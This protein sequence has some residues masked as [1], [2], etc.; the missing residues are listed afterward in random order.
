MTGHPI[1]DMPAPRS[2]ILRMDITNICNL[3]CIG[4]ALF[5]ARKALREPAASMKVETFERI[6][7]EVFPY[8]CEVAL[9]CEAEPTLHPKFSRIMQI[10]ADK[11]ERST[12]LPVRMT[13]NAT[14]LTKDRLDAIFDSGLFGLAV[15]IDGFAPE[16]FS[17]IRKKG[18]ISKVFEAMDEIVRRRTAEKREFP[19][20]QINYTLM[21]SN[22]YELMDLIKYSRRWEL[23]SFVVTHV[24]SPP[25]K[26]MSRE[27]LMDWPE[28]SN[29]ILSQA[30]AKCRKY[31]IPG[32]F[33]APFPTKPGLW[34]R[35]ASR[36]RPEPVPEPAPADSTDLACS[37][38][39][40]MLKIRWNG[41]V[42]PCDL[43]N[44]SNPLGSLETQSF[45]DIWMSEKYVELRSGLFNGNPTFH[46]CITCDRISQDNLE[47]RKLRSPLA[48]T[49]VKTTRLN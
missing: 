20:L 10:L 2:L 47:K 6:A 46:Q 41:E 22:L 45:Q 7:N 40:R 13:T 18:E 48:H 12:V 5:D 35:F 29:R 23:E 8:L 21:K 31:G 24:Y 43:W 28:E 17:K 4:C 36:L 38:P 3:D 19:R 42:H 30:E 39:W 33:P 26:D 16:T 32:R 34:S 25:G 9:S 15:S 44:A 11:T 27:S 1:F 37:A 14:T 49:S